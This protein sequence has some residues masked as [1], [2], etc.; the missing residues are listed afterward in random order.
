[1]RCGEG[2]ET[3]AVMETMKGEGYAA[4]MGVGDVLIKVRRKEGKG[5]E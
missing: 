3:L 2:G 4:P 1:M 5:R